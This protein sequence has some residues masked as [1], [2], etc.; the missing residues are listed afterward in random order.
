M[1]ESLLYV[2]DILKAKGPYREFTVRSVAPSAVIVLE[3]ETVPRIHAQVKSGRELDALKA[4]LRNDP[5]AYHVSAAFGD[6]FQ[7]SDGT[8]DL[9]R[10]TRDQAHRKRLST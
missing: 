9:D 3:C 2:E 5:A 1:E 4:W 10:F 8:F 7:T 6:T